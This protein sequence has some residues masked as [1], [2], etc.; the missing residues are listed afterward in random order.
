MNENLVHLPYFTS[1]PEEMVPPQGI[2]LSPGFLLEF[3]QALAVNSVYVWSYKL[4]AVKLKEPDV[5]FPRDE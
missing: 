3:S 5:L 2:S 1:Q 4:S